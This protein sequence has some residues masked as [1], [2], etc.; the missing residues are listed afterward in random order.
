MSV[1]VK[2]DEKANDI[3][4]AMENIHNVEEFKTLFKNMYPAD[5]ERILK[6]YA[7][8][9]RKNVKQKGHPMPEPEKYLENTYKV[10][11]SKRNNN[12]V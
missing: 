2:K 3:L 1:I 4:N 12:K 9:E 10:A 5:W 11:I 8:H 7:K 6:N